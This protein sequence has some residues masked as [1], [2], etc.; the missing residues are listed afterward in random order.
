MSQVQ[1]KMFTLLKLSNYFCQFIFQLKLSILDT[2]HRTVHNKLKTGRCFE[3]KLRFSLKL[4]FETI[5]MFDCIHIHLYLKYILCT[6]FVQ[7]KNYIHVH[8][9]NFF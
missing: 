4:Y 3:V 9:Q 6:V 1:I 5:A 2:V 8:C 7:I